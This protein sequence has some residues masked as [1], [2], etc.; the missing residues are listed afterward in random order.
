MRKTNGKDSLNFFGGPLVLDFLGQRQFFL[1]Q[2]AH[3]SR[4]PDKVAV[5]KLYLLL[6]M[7]DRR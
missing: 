7:L 5:S 3:A 4:Q 2:D 6:A 1:A